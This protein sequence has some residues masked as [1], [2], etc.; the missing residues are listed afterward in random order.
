MEFSELIEQLIDE[1]IA[2]YHTRNRSFNVDGYDQLKDELSMLRKQFLEFICK[3]IPKDPNP[4]WT[5]ERLRALELKV[6]ALEERQ[7]PEIYNG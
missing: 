7:K 2:I 5:E 6:K 4:Q 1:K 3:N